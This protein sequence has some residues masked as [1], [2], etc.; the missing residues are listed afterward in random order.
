LAVAG[1]WRLVEAGT[2][3]QRNQD[4]AGDMLLSLLLIG[5]LAAQTPSVPPVREIASGVYLQPGGFESERGPDG[6]TIIFDAPQGLV[7]VD[8]GRHSWHSDAIL[9]YARE[10]DRPIAAILNTHW[11]L[12]HTSG[13]GRLKA[14][15]PN[16]RVYSTNAVD[17]VI[18]PGGFLMRG[19]DGANAMLAGTE[20]SAVQREEVQI[21][22]DTMAESQV[23]RPDVVID[24]SQRLRVGGRRL[25]VRVTAGATTDADLWLYDRRSRIAVIGDLVT[26]P[27]PFFETA[28]P[29]RWR[30]ALDEVWATPFRTA[31]PG[32]G[33]PMTREQ[34]NVWRTAYGAFIDCAG[35]DTE[36]RACGLAWS[37]ATAQ[38]NGD[39]A[40]QRRAAGFASYYVTM[41]RENG[42][43]SADCLTN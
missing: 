41:L 7:V 23:L 15:Y 20:I 6:N 3:Q 25:D 1:F 14:V 34:F 38:F 36:P 28:C 19:L 26:F 10:R 22:L 8:T 32:H 24:R 37:Q 9:A 11:H 39:E 12:D 27:A 18:A 43:K 16:A 40:G 30:E 35:S 5:Q 2:F 33:E 42:G 29:Q 4:K 31:I 13:N 21:F 17:R